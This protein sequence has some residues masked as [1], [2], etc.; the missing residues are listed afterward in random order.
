MRFFCE[1]RRII[2]RKGRLPQPSRGVRR[3][4]PKKP[5]FANISLAFLPIFWYTDSNQCWSICAPRRFDKKARRAKDSLRAAHV[6][7]LVARIG[8]SVSSYSFA[9]WILSCIDSPFA[10]I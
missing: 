10:V 6:T 9:G 4:L 5:F 3:N 7:Y 1:N 8:F 2:L